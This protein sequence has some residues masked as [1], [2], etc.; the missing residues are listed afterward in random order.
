MCKKENKYA[1]VLSFDLCSIYMFDQNSRKSFI[2]IVIFNLF[3]NP[4]IIL[5]RTVARAKMAK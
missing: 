5:A 4:C 3:K 1:S 2:H